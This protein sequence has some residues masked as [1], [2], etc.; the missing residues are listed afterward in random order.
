[1]EFPVGYGVQCRQFLA[2]L[3]GLMP[4]FETYN[5]VNVPVTFSLFLMSGSSKLLLSPVKR[6]C[7]LSQFVPYRYPL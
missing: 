1:M 7:R 5:T 3:W 2:V 6:P 4:V